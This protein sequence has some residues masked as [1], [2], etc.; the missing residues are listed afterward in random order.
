MP[1]L[2]RLRTLSILAA[3]A[4]VAVA[5]P[6]LGQEEQEEQMETGTELV[7]PFLGTW[8]YAGTEEQGT[9]VIH[10]AVDRTVAPL[11]FVTRPF[12]A[13]RLRAKNPLVQ[14]IDISAPGDSVRIV[15]DGE[16]TYE[17]PPDQWRDHTFEDETVA[18]QIR[19]RREALVQLFRSES[20]L[21]RNVYRVTGEGQ[22]R[23]EVTV[24]SE[25]IPEDMRYQLNYRRQ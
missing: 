8:R 17:A 25:R 5:L 11:S 13:G 3:L 20:G 4:A 15:F 6:A 24:Q 16:R 23:L 10:D 22:M 7:E 12:V 1:R 18:V 9:R 14:R 19:P 2:P 21:R